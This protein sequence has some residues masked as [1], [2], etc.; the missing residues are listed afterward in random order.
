MIN[1]EKWNKA[2]DDADTFY[3]KK[4]VRVTEIDGTIFKG[5][6]GGYYE[7]ENSKGEACWAISVGQRKFIQEDV[8]KIEFI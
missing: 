8:E 7:D 3:G 4:N 6:C 2:V 1:S 5:I